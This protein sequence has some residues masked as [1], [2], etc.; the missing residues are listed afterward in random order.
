MK[1]Q[2]VKELYPNQFVKFQILKS[3]I[4]AD[5]EYVDEIALIGPVEEEN[6]TRE[7]LNAKD[8]ILVYH[9]SKDKVKLKIRTRIGLRRAY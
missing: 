2:E 1:W 3:H 4:E 7:L 9:T 5:I 8:N 6:A